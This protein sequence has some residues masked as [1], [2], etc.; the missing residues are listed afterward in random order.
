MDKDIIE[1]TSLTPVYLSQ[2]DVQV[3]SMSREDVSVWICGSLLVLLSLNRVCL[4][5]VHIRLRKLYSCRRVAI[6]L[7]TLRQQ[8]IFFPQHQAL[9]LLHPLHCLVH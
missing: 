1:M 4:F 2:M 6:Y 3:E 5:N 8:D 7:V 9:L